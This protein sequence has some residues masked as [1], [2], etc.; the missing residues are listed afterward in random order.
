MS[1]NFKLIA[2]VLTIFLSTS[3]FSQKNLGKEA[4]KHFDNREFY[5]AAGYYKKAYE[6]E[7]KAEK[8]ARFLFQMGECHRHINQ[9]KEAESYYTKAIKAKIGRAHV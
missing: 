4:D 8:K 3:I 1:N 2:F 6:K 9:L 5:L 7:K